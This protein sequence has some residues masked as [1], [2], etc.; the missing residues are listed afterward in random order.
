MCSAPQRCKQSCRAVHDAMRRG[1]GR[2]SNCSPLWK[3]PLW[4]E[5][6]RKVEKGGRGG[7]RGRRDNGW[8]AR[9]IDPCRVFQ[10]CW[11]CEAGGCVI[12]SCAAWVWLYKSNYLNFW[13][14]IILGAAI[15]WPTGAGNGKKLSSSQAQLGQENAWLL[16]SFFPFPVG[17]PVAAHSKLYLIQYW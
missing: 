14:E 12:L 16:L 2:E 9:A 3:S 1:E 5:G 11:W 8:R 7:W 13:F 4:E 10:G 6:G 17:H 15:G